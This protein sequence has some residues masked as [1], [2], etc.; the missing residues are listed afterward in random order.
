MKVRLVRIDNS[1]GIRIPQELLSP[2]RLKEGTELELEQRR[3]GLLIRAPGSS[4]AEL[5]WGAA[6]REMDA[7]DAERTEW[8][9]GDATAGHQRWRDE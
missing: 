9:D 8:R 4:V 6:Y 7:E 5:P 2:Y 3:E 1:R